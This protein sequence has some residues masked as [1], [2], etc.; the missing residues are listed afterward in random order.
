[1]P[2]LRITLSKR[3]T[4]VIRL[5]SKTTWPF[6]SG[7]F[8]GLQT[9]TIISTERRY[10][11]QDLKTRS[12]ARKLMRHV[13]ECC[14]LRIESSKLKKPPVERCEHLKQATS[15]RCWQKL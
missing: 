14:S 10:S 4:Y 6:F 15:D 13:R 7:K 11:L 1:M 8:K 2:L 5:G 12:T 3:A 9:H